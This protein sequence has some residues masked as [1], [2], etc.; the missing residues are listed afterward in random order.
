MRLVGIKDFFS[1]EVLARNYHV[2]QVSPKHDW[3]V[4]ALPGGD[5]FSGHVPRQV[6]SG[7]RD[8]HWPIRDR[9]LG[10]FTLYFPTVTLSRVHTP[11]TFPDSPNDLL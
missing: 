11:P 7:I 8:R 6:A 5:K 10:Q 4:K 1:A 3:N 2:P 9:H